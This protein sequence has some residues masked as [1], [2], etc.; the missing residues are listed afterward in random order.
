MHLERMSEIT[1]LLTLG[2]FELAAR[3]PPKPEDDNRTIFVTDVV[4][5][6][7]ATEWVLWPRPDDGAGAHLAKLLLLPDLGHTWRASLCRE[8]W[9]LPAARDHAL[10]LVQASL[11]RELPIRRWV[12]LGVRV[13]RAFESAALQL[14]DGGNGIPRL[15][16]ADDLSQVVTW[17][18]DRH[19]PGLW[20]VMTM[21]HPST[22]NR[23][24]NTPEMSERVRRV[25]H[26]QLVDAR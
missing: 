13:Q 12:L 17:D 10:A 15:T 25:F 19:G 23:A 20:R 2:R 11:D 22:R 21:P 1:Q 6:S 7:M 9:S 14:Y 3:M 16:F 24:W 5:A 4:P 8:R 18:V 26:Q